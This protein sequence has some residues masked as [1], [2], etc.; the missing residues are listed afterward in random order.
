MS[1]QV[2]DNDNQTNDDTPP[3]PDTESPKT[4]DEGYVRELRAEAAK[5]RKELRAT[6]AQLAEFQKTQEAAEAK[7]LEEQGEWQKLAE[8]EVAR[9]AE[10]EQ[11]LAAR[12]Q[13]LNDEKRAR[14]AISAATTLGAIDPSDANFE[15]AVSGIDISEPDAQAKIEQALEALKASRPYLF[16]GHRPSLASFNPSGQEQVAQG[17]TDAERRARLYGGGLRIFDTRRAEE[18]GGGAVI[19]KGPTKPE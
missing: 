14:L 6:Q 16:Q 13:M 9:R 12:E 15:A 4:F 19:V 8:Q 10:L 11:E 18:S 17:E 2:L 3:N 1:D 5:H 7:K